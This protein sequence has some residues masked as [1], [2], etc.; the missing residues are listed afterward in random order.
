[1]EFSEKQR[2]VVDH[3]RGSLLVSAAAGSGKTTTLIAHIAEQL[4]EPDPA[5]RADLSRFIV[6]TYTN[7]AAAEMKS[8]L[9][10]ELSRL[11]EEQP[12]A[13]YLKAQLALVPQARISTV[14]SLC[15]YL[16]RNYFARI[17]VSPDLRIAED[18]E[19][20]LLQSDVTEALFEERYQ[21]GDRDF[22]EL[23][24]C[25]GS[26]KGDSALRSM[27]QSLYQSAQNDPFPADWLANA[28]RPFPDSVPAL[29]QEPWMQQRE[30]RLREELRALK[31]EA[32]AGLARMEEEEHAAYTEMFRKDLVLFR[33][34]LEAPDEEQLQ[35]RLSGCRFEA[36]PPM[37]GA[38][39]NP[40]LDD[41]VSALRGSASAPRGYLSCLKKLKEQ[42][43]PLTDEEL[44]R[45][46]A[47][48][49][50]RATLCRLAEDFGE[51][52]EEAMKKRN[53]ADFMAL[54][55]MAL[56]LLAE[57]DGE[58][59]IVPTALARELQGDFDEII[60]DEYQDINN[61]QELILLCLSGELTGRPNLFMV[62]DVKQSIY[63]FRRANPGLFLAKYR[64]F[65]YE[66]D[67]PHRKIDLSENYRS[68]RT[69]LAAVND[70]FERIMDT[71]FGGLAYDEHARLRAG[72]SFAT[73]GEAPAL[74]LL[75]SDA[76]GE[77]RVRAEAAMIGKRIRRLMDER[78]LLDNGKGGTRPLTYRDIVI[79]LRN[80]GSAKL[81][82]DTL[83][84]MGI[85][86]T[87]PLK[88]GFY[89]TQEI[90]TLMALL[91]VIDN[92][93]NDIP[94]AAVLTSP[95]AG[96]SDGLLAELT[97]GA[98]PSELTLYDRLQG[99]LKREPERYPQL[100]RFTERLTAWRE[101]SRSRGIPELLRDILTES[102]YELY[103][104]AMPGGR[105][106][107]ANVELLLDQAR[108]FESTSY[109]G[110][111][112]FNRYLKR[113][114][115]AQEDSGE[116][117]LG[118]EEENLVHIGTIHS[119]KGLE[120]PVVFV[121]ELDKDFNQ[122]DSK[123]TLLI[124]EELGLALPTVIPSERLK[125]GNL[126]QILLKSR[127]QEEAKAEEQRL[128]YVAMTRAKER[129]Y[130][131]G[132]LKDAASWQ[133]LYPA[134]QE[135]PAGPLPSATVRRGSCY[136][137]WLLMALCSGQKA[138]KVEVQQEEGLVRE[139]AQRQISL[140][141]LRR[142]MESLEQHPAPVSERLRA[143]LSWHYPHEALEG[144]KGVYSVSELKKK[145]QEAQ[146]GHPAAEAGPAV[147]A[148]SIGA[149]ANAGQ[150]SFW[151]SD[152]AEP[153]EGPL[154]GAEKGTIFHKCLE[155][156]V[157]EKCVTA[158]GVAQ[159]LEQLKTGGFLTDRELTAVRPQDILAFYQSPQGAR[160]IEA[161]RRGRLHREQP[162]IMSL[163]LEEICPGTGSREQALVQGIIDLYLEEEDGL[164]LMDYKT[165]RV[166]SEEELVTRYRVQ[167][168]YYRRALEAASGKCVKECYL[169]SVALRQ[170]I[171]V[172]F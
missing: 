136:L 123:A 154:T 24:R 9:A 168:D 23:V 56:R 103:L 4:A 15:N 79:Y 33:H 55:H 137:D 35:Q 143:R 44:R 146:D 61:L 118:G 140:E 151:H 124:H 50:P 116:A 141:A 21:R 52:L 122:S 49:R 104:G 134:L 121:A 51:A 62:G 100:A 113:L 54:E 170:W 153:A 131:S 36:K 69:V 72:A 6:V 149:A 163:P 147:Q 11:A 67:A 135:L 28:A 119:G 86:A 127:M 37:R 16:V 81:F 25:C 12:R 150:D 57:K 18:S 159:G 138:L 139:A 101:A 1:M 76:S 20:K 13:E 31:Q 26:E 7:A 120:S 90:Q 3:R 94:L 5:K 41:Y 40:E 82:A 73:P 2:Q 71:P 32:E 17:D 132:C 114:L 19:M 156:L 38:K 109:R 30:E 45:L 98:E 39:K 95:L 58:G 161:S 42:Y 88:H 96:F 10:R 167:L 112:Q 29:R 48:D 84:A 74:L 111:Y 85:P 128:L 148:A 129:L 47:T 8:R 70:V 107:L 64:D 34:F 102:G 171:G 162:F 105:V 91:A 66:E 75:V 89:Q 157:P 97:A 115:E 68:Q 142:E 169:Y 77:D 46:R 155:L 92:P 152:K 60:V 83:S 80:M 158:E 59:R 43:A 108:R 22:L 93:R 99:A 117:S 164:V 172:S 160:V 53:I 125:C 126:W 78:T 145:A 110:L 144:V 65:A 87:A 166:K 106:R 27:V 133:S 63:R 165:D 130:L 14:D